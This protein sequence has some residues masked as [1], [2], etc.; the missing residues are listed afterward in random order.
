MRL[1]FFLLLGFLASCASH[2]PGPL[3]PS[4]FRTQTDESG[5]A[6][7]AFVHGVKADLLTLNHQ[8]V[9]R[10]VEQPRNER[11]QA[12]GAQKDDSRSVSTSRKVIFNSNRLDDVGEADRL[13]RLLAKDSRHYIVTFVVSDDAEYER[14]S[15]LYEQRILVA[16]RAQ[17]HQTGRWLRS[18]Y[19]VNRDTLQHIA[20]EAIQ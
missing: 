9:V 20:I 17:G 12:P 10:W 3:A 6:T 13:L 18:G 15:G 1:S 16:A 7:P 11:T 5:D 19:Q 4:A 14:L 2:D 8:S